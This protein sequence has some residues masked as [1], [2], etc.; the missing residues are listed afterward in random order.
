MPKNQT[1]AV[2][3]MHDGERAQVFL[4]VAPGGSV[5][6]YLA[7]AGRFMPMGFAEGT[8]LVAREAIAA[9]GIHVMHAAIED[10]LPGERQTAKLH[11]RSGGVIKG[12]LRWV[13]PEGARRTLD[14]MNNDA[15]YVVVYDT[16]HVVYV[17]K[18]HIALVEEV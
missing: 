5:G 14:F 11:L 13:A 4:F 18:Q 17:A 16:E 9:L 1:P 8:R 6:H 3:T 7:E 10:E 12:E 15:S 2:L